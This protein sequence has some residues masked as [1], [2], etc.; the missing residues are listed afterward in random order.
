MLYKTIW[1]YKFGLPLTK[2]SK[3]ARNIYELLTNDA[4]LIP[5]NAV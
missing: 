5:S 4:G 3:T 1:T 2:I